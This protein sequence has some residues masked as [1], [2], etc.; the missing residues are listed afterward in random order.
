[1]NCI[2]AAGFVI[3]TNSGKEIPNSVGFMFLGML[4]AMLLLVA[5]IH[6]TDPRK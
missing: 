1:M 4:A 6:F 5:I 2:V 3:L